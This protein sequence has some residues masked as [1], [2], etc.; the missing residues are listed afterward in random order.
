VRAGQ[1][2]FGKILFIITRITHNNDGPSTKET[3]ASRYQINHSSQML[4]N[5]FMR[6]PSKVQIHDGGP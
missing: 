4:K 5:Q 2:V 3:D 6:S 1:R